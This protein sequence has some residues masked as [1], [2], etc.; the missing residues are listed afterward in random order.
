MFLFF[1]VARGGLR[2]SL[3]QQN[4]Y[5]IEMIMYINAFHLVITTVV[6]VIH[7]CTTFVK[8]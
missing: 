8:E 5:A 3:S 6:N 4:V 2:H 1:F 7:P